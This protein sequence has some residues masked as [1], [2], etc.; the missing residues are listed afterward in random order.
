LG[1][2]LNQSPIWLKVIC[3]RYLS[4]TLLRSNGLRKLLEFIIQPT[5]ADDG[6]LAFNF[7]YTFQ[8]IYNIIIQYDM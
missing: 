7:L 2:N 3:G 6:K 8:L 1:S 5:S 4:K